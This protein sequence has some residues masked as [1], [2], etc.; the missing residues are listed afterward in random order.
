MQALCTTNKVD[1]TGTNAKAELILT[2]NGCYKNFVAADVEP[3]DRYE[4]KADPAKIG[5]L[6]ECPKRAKEL[7]KE[8][9]KTQK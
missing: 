5:T 8:P 7:A 9:V 1:A 3:K 6:I 2:P 4:E